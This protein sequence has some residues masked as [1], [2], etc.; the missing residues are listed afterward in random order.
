MELDGYAGGE[1]ADCLACGVPFE[2]P[3]PKVKTKRPPALPSVHKKA[4]DPWRKQRENAIAQL[5]AHGDDLAVVDYSESN[6]YPEDEDDPC[7][8]FDGVIFSISGRDQ[9]F[10]SYQNLIDAGLWHDQCIC[11][12]SRVDELIDRDEIN[13]QAN[14]GQPRRVGE[15][16]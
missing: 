3:Y 10:P 4:C 16:R 7:E 14:S 9:R 8:K 6:E 2:V 13:K 1:L 5:M 15:Y 11:G 12:I